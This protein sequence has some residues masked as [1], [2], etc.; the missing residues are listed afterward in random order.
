MSSWEALEH[1][2]IRPERF[3]YRPTDALGPNIFTLLG[4]VYQ[5]T[6][7]EIK[8]ARGMC[9]QCSHFEPLESQREEEEMPCVIYLHGNCGSRVD[10]LESAEVLLPYG[11]TVFA[12]DFS[13]SGLSDGDYVSL[14][15]FEKEDV[16]AVVEHLRGSGRVSTI[17]LW[18]RSM[19]AA[20]SI[21]Y[22]SGDPSIAG[23]VCDSPFA[24]LV[25]V[26]HD[27]VKGYKSW[28]PKMFVSV[29]IKAMRRSIRNHACFDI[30]DVSPVRAAE[31][32]FVPCLIG[33]AEGD[34]FIRIRHAEEVHDKYQGEKNLVRFDGDHNSPR[35]EFFLDSVL[36]FFLNT[37]RG[38]FD[39]TSVQ[40]ASSM[41]GDGAAFEDAR[42]FLVSGIPPG[43]SPNRRKA[44]P[45]GEDEDGGDYQLSSDDDDDEVIRARMIAQARR[46]SEGGARISQRRGM[47]NDVKK[48][49]TSGILPPLLHSPGHQMV[50]N[51]LHST[52]PVCA[53]NEEE[54]VDE[55]ERTLRLAEGSGEDSSDYDDDDDDDACV[56]GRSSPLLS[57][58]RADLK[59]ILK[60]AKKT[61]ARK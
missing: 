1:L 49:S 47:E 60:E 18:G 37:L 5:R 40:P 50:L 4:K 57:A 36:I 54:L 27:L 23:I 10:A 59:K 34:D 20:T 8:N 39:P 22:A 24:S 15:H 58:S 29:G 48:L 32:C 21:L 42:D 6:D 12:F 41:W 7:I 13:G 46:G 28:I 61:E 9:L 2:V 38:I 45:L 52:G 26:M 56:D 25:Q 33:H 44:I 35:P 30:R 11:I 55:L 17:G 16:R 3:I 31:V 53:L 51:G 14:G 43:M 19:G